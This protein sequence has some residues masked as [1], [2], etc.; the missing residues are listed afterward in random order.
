VLIYNIIFGEKSVLWA[1]AAIL[2]PCCIPPAFGQSPLEP[3]VLLEE[4]VLQPPVFLMISSIGHSVD[5][6]SL[7][8]LTVIRTQDSYGKGIKRRVSLGCQT[9]SFSLKISPEVNDSL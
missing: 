8:C 1:T 7:L 2:N 4:S 3:T 9:L 6:E 5:F